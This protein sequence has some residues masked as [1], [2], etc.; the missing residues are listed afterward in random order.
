MDPPLP[1]VPRIAVI[2]CGYWGRNLVRNFHALGSLAAVCDFSAEGR[3]L[4]TQLAPGARVLDQLAVLLAQPDIEGIALATPAHTHI[5]LGLDILRAGKDLFVEK[6]MALNLADAR[7]LAET[8]EAGARMLQVG[9][10]LEYHPAFLE[11][12]DG[13]QAGRIGQLRLIESRRCNFGKVRTEEDALWSLAPHDIAMIL[14]LAGRAPISVACHGTYALGTARADTAAAVLH[15]EGRLTAHVMCSWI[16]PVKEQRLSAIGDEGAAVFDDTSA[17]RKLAWQTQRVEWENSQPRL[18]KGPAEAGVHPK[19]EPLRLECAAFLSSIS[20][21]RNPVT[22]AASGVR[23]VS[24]LEACQASM[25]S[26]GK[27]VP[28]NLP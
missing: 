18:S 22:D 21:R 2:G 10:L 5:S 3:A 4:A 9:H 6:P 8:A 27:P 13:V 16:H 23:V 12:R 15:F 7:L 28:L 20:S 1:K 24:V 26:G 14:R 25:H 19:D 11:L 17:D